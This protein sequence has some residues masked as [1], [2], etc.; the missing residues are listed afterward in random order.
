[1]FTALHVVLAL[2]WAAGAFVET[3]NQC[4]VVSWGFDEWLYDQAKVGH[5]VL[6]SKKNKG[7]VRS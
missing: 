4:S 3:N 6:L 2:S 1:M 5:G 7:P